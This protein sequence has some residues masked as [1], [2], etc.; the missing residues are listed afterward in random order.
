MVVASSRCGTK[1]SNRGGRNSS[2]LGTDRGL[3]EATSLLWMPYGMPGPA[4]HARFRLKA[5]RLRC[6]RPAVAEVQKEARSET[7]QKIYQPTGVVAFFPHHP[8]LQH[9]VGLFLSLR[10]SLSLSLSLS[11][12]HEGDVGVLEPVPKVAV[13]VAR[14]AQG[15][16]ARETR[17]QQV[18]EDHRTP[19]AAQLEAPAARRHIVR[20]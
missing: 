10:L 13:P 20:E 19:G 17:P 15:R 14:R 5:Q 3:V 4:L 6:A 2:S 11:L 18:A 16:V 8:S 9:P 7:Q 1:N 12:Q